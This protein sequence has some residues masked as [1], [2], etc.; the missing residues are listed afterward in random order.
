MFITRIHHLA[1]ILA[2]AA[3]ATAAAQ[4]V[5]HVDAAAPG[6]G[7]GSTWATAFNDLQAALEAAEAI[8]SPATPVEIRVAAG[9]YRPDPTGLDD[10]REAT[11]QLLDDVSLLG[12]F[13]TGGAPPSERDPDAHVTILRGDLDG[14]GAAV[15]ECVAL[16]AE[17]TG[18]DNCYHVVTGSFTDHTAVLDGFTIT[19]GRAAS[20][21]PGMY[22]ANGSPTVRNC[23]FHANSGY[24]GAA[25]CNMGDS[26]PTITNCTFSANW[27]GNWGG[28]IVFES[29]ATRPTLTNCVFSGNETWGQ[30]GAL[31]GGGELM[32]VNCVF[33]GNVAGQGGGALYSVG[34]SV[35]V[36]CAFVGNRSD[37]GSVLSAGDPNFIN[38]I[39][40]ANVDTDATG[41]TTGLS[42]YTR[43]VTYSCVQGPG[44]PG[45]G[46]INADPRFVREPDPGPDGN[47]DGVDDDYGDLRLLPGSPCID[48]GDNTA[49]PADV[50]TDV[51]GGPRFQDDP[52][53]PDTGN[54]TPP[55]VD[56]G[57]YEVL[58]VPCLIRIVGGTDAADN[59]ASLVWPKAEAV[60]LAAVEIEV[61]QA[62]TLVGSSVVTT[63]GASTPA[64]SALTHV[65][66]GIHQV[67]LTEPIPVGHWTIVTLTVA[68]ATAS[69]STFELC[70]GHLP[71]DT[72]GD[73]DVNMSDVTDF[74]ALFNGDPDAPQRERIDL[75]ADG[76][77]N[78]NDVTLFGQLWQGTSGHDAWQ[79][80][81]LPAK[82]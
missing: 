82:P 4:T 5:L 65:A 11:F 52:D 25:M 77:A 66:G 17:P 72:N 76:Q 26:S 43:S 42:S 67:E 69:E 78:L 49:V 36:N 45:L 12:G 14:G 41:P 7:D 21:G 35:F 13:P 63:G 75:N 22:N 33:V 79:G 9:T 58:G 28:A 34:N 73:A 15:T 70:L 30:G 81:S 54:G 31:A 50:T 2:L 32:L 6:G 64:V 20:D 29:S 53:T 27:S 51:N 48:A 62:V 18:A 37:R 38:C 47:W 61:D 44:C 80:Q 1:L 16:F 71:A 40:W 68:D 23:V 56:M 60:G 46:N 74:G 59:S 55:I 57:A 8:A 19:D 39:F 3:A 24:L 10:P